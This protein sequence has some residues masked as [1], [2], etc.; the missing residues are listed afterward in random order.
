MNNGRQAKTLVVFFSRSG[1]TRRIAQALAQRL[2]A[3]LEDL[4]VV[5]P[6]EGP[7]GY[8]QSALEALAMMAPAIDPPLHDG[9]GHE[10][11]VI[12]SPVW[13][14]S[15]ASPVRSWLLRAQLQHA[16]V[17]FFCTM[18]G[19]GAW[20][21]FDAMSELAGQKP[22]ATLALTEHEVEARQLSQLD[23]FALALKNSVAAPA[24]KAMRRPPRRASRSGARARA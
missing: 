17:A 3:E 6:R 24:P 7:I 8:A 14:W 11:V 2:N 4:S 18:G 19:S 9:S 10:L 5:Q 1:H 16:R 15:L 22:V 23:E 13:C 20:R 12:G 21:V